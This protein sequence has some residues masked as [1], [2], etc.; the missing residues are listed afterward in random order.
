M[1]APTYYGLI[2]LF[3]N[4]PKIPGDAS[5]GIHSTKIS[6]GRHNSG[7]KIKCSNWMNYVVACSF[8]MTWTIMKL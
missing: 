8:P 6:H 7:E 3:T 4:I 5:M 1:Y 2:S